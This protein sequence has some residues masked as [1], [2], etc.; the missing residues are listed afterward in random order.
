MRIEPESTAR[1]RQLGS[2]LSKVWIRLLETQLSV[3]DLV[4]SNADISYFT[5]NDQRVCVR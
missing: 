2:P 3:K 5:G 1:E 4:I